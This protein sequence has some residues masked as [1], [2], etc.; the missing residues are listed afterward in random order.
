MA[1]LRLP[2]NSRVTSG[3]H[4]AAPAGAGRTKTFRVYRYDPDDAANP[5]WDTY[6]V[7]VDACGPM[8]LDVLIQSRT[9]WTRR[10]P[11]VAR[12]AR[13]SAARAP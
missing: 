3:R 13:G 1:E 5:R 12:V 4:H 10:S 6:E 9:P 7:D 8:V 11:S 2:K